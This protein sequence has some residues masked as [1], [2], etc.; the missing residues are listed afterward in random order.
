MNK[1]KNENI[2]VAANFTPVARKKYRVGVPQKCNYEVVFSTDWKK[3]GG[4][5]I[6][7]TK[8]YKAKKT[9]AGSM[10][11]SIDVDLAGLS[12]VYIMAIPD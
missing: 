7:R 9:P 11:Y 3:F 6:Q 1:E 10:P 8:K 2:I 5:K 12:A 4:E